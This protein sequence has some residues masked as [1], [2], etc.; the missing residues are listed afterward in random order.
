MKT[1]FLELKSIWYYRFALI[2]VL[3]STLY[4][5]IFLL[6]GPVSYEDSS[7]STSQLRQYIRSVLHFLWAWFFYFLF[8]LLS[9]ILIS[10]TFTI[11]VVP[12]DIQI[13]FPSI[14]K[15]HDYIVPTKDLFWP[16]WIGQV[17]VVRSGDDS[18]KCIIGF[19]LY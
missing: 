7:T 1:C 2:R 10:Y 6:K 4:V 18:Q 9:T 11:L 15:S 14:S 19:R 12:S 13:W 3:R 8:D 17:D 5:K 16:S